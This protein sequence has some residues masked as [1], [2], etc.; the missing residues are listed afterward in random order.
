MAG[1][2]VR[3]PFYHDRKRPPGQNLHPTTAMKLN[4]GPHIRSNAPPSAR[5][6]ERGV[7]LVTVLAIM[8][9]MTVLIMSF[10]TMSKNELT[11]SLKDSDNMRARSYADAAVNMVISQIRSATTRVASDGSTILPWAS[12]PGAIR[13]FQPHGALQ[14]IVKLYSSS[15]MTATNAAMI[16]S[17]DLQTNWDDYPDVWVDMNEPVIIP[18][19]SRPESLA[20]AELIFPIADPRAAASLGNNDPVEGF[21]YEATGVRGIVRGS[22]GASNSQRLPMPVKWIY[23]LADG[24]VGTLTQGG[25]FV[26]A[27]GSSSP[28][29]ENPIVGR[30]AF[31]TDDET[32]K[33]NVNT[34][35]EGVYWDTPRTSSREDQLLGRN[36]PVSGEYQRYPGHPAMVCLSSVLFPNKRLRAEGSERAP[37]DS[38]MK[39]LTLEEAQ[40]IWRM[41][42]YIYGE[43]DEKTSLGGTQ[44]A[45]P[46]KKSATTNANSIQPGQ[47]NSLK[48]F[49]LGKHLYN[50][51]DD[52]IIAAT[53]DTD[54]N[55]TTES[56]NITPKVQ[57][58]QT[59]QQ[60]SRFPRMRAARALDR[61]KQGRFFLTTRSSAPEITL[62]GTPRVSLWPMSAD[63]MSRLDKANPSTGSLA[64][65]KFTAYDMLIGFNASIRQPKNRKN[66]NSGYN[67]IPFFF[68][69]TQAGYRHGEF[70]DHGTPVGHNR[71][72]WQYVTNV[73]ARPIPGF[74][75]Q[76]SGGGSENTR[77]F[78]DFAEKYGA[79]QY[80]DL[81]A[82][83]GMFIDY[84]RNQNLYDPN[85]RPANYYSQPGASDQAYGQVTSICFCR[86]SGFHNDT[87]SDARTLYSKGIGRLPTVS[88]VALLITLR[89]KR[90]A[91]GLSVGPPFQRENRDRADQLPMMDH[92]EVEVG[93]LIEGFVAAQG[94][95]EIHP[96]MSFVLAG[97]E[98]ANKLGQRRS[99]NGATDWM[100]SG[101]G[102]Y[103]PLK[104]NGQ[105][106]VFMG[107][108]GLGSNATTGNSSNALAKDWI[109][110]GGTL[111]VRW[112]ENMIV[113][114]PVLISV[115]PGTVPTTI[116][117][118]GTLGGTEHLRLISLDSRT[119]GS[120]VS[121]SLEIG[122][123][124]Q[125]F[126]LAFPGFQANTNLFQDPNPDGLRRM[127]SAGN[128][129]QQAGNTAA[130]SD[131]Y[132][133]ARDNADNL[134]GPNGLIRPWD[135]VK[136]LVPVHGDFRLL[137]G[138]RIAML[139]KDNASAANA[140]VTEYPVFVPHPNYFT[141]NQAHS[142][143]EPKP[144]V[145]LKLRQARGQGDPVARTDANDFG[146]F[147]NEPGVRDLRLEPEYMPDFPIKPWSNERMQIIFGV[148][149]TNGGALSGGTLRTF[150]MSQLFEAIRMDEF[151][152]VN[153]R[154][155]ARP[156]YTGDFDNGV[157]PSMD[158]PYS[159][160]GDE[161]EVRGARDSS[162]YPYFT[163]LEP[164]SRAFN[165]TPPISQAM[166][167]P[168][169]LVPSP[170]VLGSLPTGVQAN[171]P[172][173]TVLLRP[174]P[175]LHRRNQS[176]PRPERRH[177]GSR[178][179]RDHLFMDAFWMPV[180][181][182]YAISEP[183]ETKGKINMN[184]QILPFTY[185]KRTT[186][187]RALLKSEKILA[188]PNEDTDIYKIG[189]TSPPNSENGTYLSSE[190][191]G[192]RQV[193]FR[194]FIDADET[195]RQWDLRFEG[196]DE[197]S[198]SRGGNQPA[199][200]FLSPTQI[201]DLW[202]VP[203]GQKLEDM[204]EFWDNHRMT[205]DNARER[206]YA[207]LYPRLTTRSNTYRVFVVAQALRKNSRSDPRVFDPLQGDA[208]T[209]EYKG[210]YLV[211]RSINPADPDIPHYINIFA[212]AQGGQVAYDSLD[213]FY[214][215]RITQ[216]KQFA[217]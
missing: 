30:V 59:I 55:Q 22:G 126:P 41:S 49:P 166:F 159:G 141:H 179:P 101:T 99:L 143:T 201:C 135:I 63:I 27:P 134:L 73:L 167:S 212:N 44:M 111:G 25:E 185:I 121:G 199:G 123:I 82:I 79:T 198:K 76:G 33:I 107:S 127:N 124:F 69:R 17:Q 16:R 176:Q 214:Y 42:P 14:Q 189:R 48:G 162:G 173:Q 186:A 194:H 187:L 191:G 193:R 168:N 88:E 97:Y 24:S 89:S 18:N 137:A 177:Y 1:A 178:F 21:S 131:R 96:Q 56:S 207:N 57:E 103:T 47:L 106:L 92:Y 175:E 171:V 85:L 208:V 105:D 34:A 35:S 213:K 115:A 10:F 145:N 71:K 196:Q 37:T 210:S 170:G 20:N 151:N 132:S 140:D 149:P 165:S 19:P 52:Y 62:H 78:R 65:A 142:L 114:K 150:A 74:T 113:F 156:D 66:P 70:N 155:A 43:S 112:M 117:F 160:R 26:A 147:T 172:W 119:T 188:I 136:S 84:I 61:I 68:Q 180:V 205:G 40:E 5:P 60:D 81:P 58:R 146:Y 94:W 83:A 153:R 203:E 139:V 211:E 8:L 192:S 195:L 122:N 15:Q 64:S 51:Y 50:T 6:Q 128:G 31:W 32:C 138:R 130:T 217:R 118:S 86:G 9:L 116:N 206:P 46:V 109:G 202:L 54:P 104:L 110:W 158:G 3:L 67:V 182:P 183:F 23:L 29:K 184:H 53:S 157:G 80:E 200:A 152:G 45:E 36:Q 38:K 13:V 161:G 72:L 95:G 144:E 133:R 209:A 93:L 75:L 91:S 108:N 39:D 7:A 129:Y 174:D 98:T 120:T 102:N 197:E 181:Q 77:S 164:V 204:A 11:A 90:L 163:R 154:N 100:V 190:E 169:R 28:S 2:R 125:V 216:V 87:W 12:Q 148:Q 4:P 215:Y